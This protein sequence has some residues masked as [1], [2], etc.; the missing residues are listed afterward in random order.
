[1]FI[2]SPHEQVARGVHAGRGV[3]DAWR[4]GERTAG[5]G[6]SSR[7]AAVGAPGMDVVTCA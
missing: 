7:R 4:A 6:L 5:C 2:G 3:P 1:M